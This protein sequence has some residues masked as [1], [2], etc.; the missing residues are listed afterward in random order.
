[1]F[2]LWRQFMNFMLEIPGGIG[3]S[4]SMRTAALAE[5]TRKFAD[6][7]AQDELLK[8]H[9][10][11]IAPASWKRYLDETLTIEHLFTYGKS[12]DKLS[13]GDYHCPATGDTT[14]KA[15]VQ[16]LNKAWAGT[17][18]VTADLSGRIELWFKAVL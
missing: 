12:N 2:P 13:F 9:L 5:L 11:T 6:Q 14:M 17:V 15:Q 10:V 16:A 3:R 8:K 7:A 4:I 1:M 18:I